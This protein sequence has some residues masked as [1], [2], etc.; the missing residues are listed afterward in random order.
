MTEELCLLLAAMVSAAAN[1]LA[2]SHVLGIKRLTRLG[3]ASVAEIARASAPNK[4]VALLR[5]APWSGWERD[6]GTELRDCRSD[7]ER[8]AAIN[9][10]LRSVE[11]SLSRGRSWPAAAVW[12]A[13]SG[14]LLCLIGG[15]VLGLRAELL[16]VLPIGMCGVNACLIAG[17]V[18]R[19]EALARRRRIDRIV[20][21]V[22][23][24]LYERDVMIPARGRPRRT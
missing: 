19:R 4:A 12:L 1:G 2:W 7:G 14:T 24:D 6:L 3:D 18:G 10:A 16:G 23:G 15:F 8:V 21:A 20:A 5:V 13:G 9:A 11:H 22:A 17:R